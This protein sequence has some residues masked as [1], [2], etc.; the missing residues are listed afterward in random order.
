MTVMWKL[1][2]DDKCSKW[3]YLFVLL[4][5]LVLSFSVRIYFDKQYAQSVMNDK[6]DLLIENITKDYY[7]TMKNMYVAYHQVGMLIMQD[8][9]IASMVE[10]HQRVK[11][12]E[13]LKEEY[14]LLKRYDPYLYVMHFFNR[15]NITILRM[16]KPEQFD[17]DLTELR[18]IVAEVNRNKR[19]MNG[20]EVGKNGITYRLTMP[21]ITKDQN[22]LGV[23]EFGIRPEYFV[24]HLNNIYNLHSKIL[25]DSNAMKKLSNGRSFEHYKNFSVVA[26]DSVFSEFMHLVDLSQPKQIIEHKG[27]TYIVLTNLN[28][29]NYKNEVVGKIVVAKNITE[30][31]K[32][33]KNTII[34]QNVI[35][36]ILLLLVFT[37]VAYVFKLYTKRILQRDSLIQTLDQDSKELKD[38]ANTDDLTGIYNRRFFDMTLN[39]YLKNEK[40]ASILYF[41]IDHFKS[42]NDTYGHLMGDEILKELARTV[43]AILRPGDIFA[44]WGGEEFVILLDGASLKSAAQKAE[45]VRTTLMNHEFPE[46]LCLTVSIGVKAL[47]YHLSDREHMHILDSRMYRAKSSGRNRVVMSD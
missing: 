18:P 25:I 46:G 11:L 1:L 32:Q 35:N 16:H 43:V 4:V 20:F 31:V 6:I 15:E 41:D 30:Y 9:D 36:F 12:H 44:R 34:L 19:S 38:R 24:E 29:D 42:I 37:L 13:R 45:Q 7:A 28:L 22:Y 8:S 27:E 23:L 2:C 39:G 10:K 47:E 5:I 40:A 33:S 3:Q 14:E 17:D 26:S 21:F